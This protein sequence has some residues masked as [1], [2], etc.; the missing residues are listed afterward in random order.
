[1]LLSAL[2]F[3]AMTSLI[4][5]LGHDYSPA[6]QTFY[7]QSAGLLVLAPLILR[8]PA[9]AFRA[10]RHDLLLFRA[11]AGTIGLVLA[12]YAFQE[13]PLAEANA[14]SFTR[15]LWLIPLAAYFLHETVG[16][17]RFGAAI[18]GFGGTLLM[19]APSLSG[20]AP[21]LPAL[22]ALG[23]AL[24]FALTVTGMKALTR[25]HTIMSLTVWSAAL[26]FVFSAPIA[27]LNWQWPAP[28]DLF[29]LC[30]MGVLGLVNQVFYMKGMS[31]GD[32][33]A[34]APL[35]YTR[36][37][38]AIIL[39]MAAFHEVPNWVTILGALIVIGS[40]LVITIR[41]E[42]LNRRRPPPPME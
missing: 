5:Y 39:G 40:T 42:R 10:S 32:A 13:M 41:E 17:W 23:S 37:V 34:M 36:L 35:D 16:V 25:D 19:L 15:S 22:A 3:T 1:M 20:Q 29:L 28:F 38:F 24:L 8:D 26:G 33:A 27:A 21:L 4:K 2:T 7:R 6:T 9:A 18:V 31:L 14:L 11:A 12:F 30:L